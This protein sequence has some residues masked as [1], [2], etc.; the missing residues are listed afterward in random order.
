MTFQSVSSSK[1][2]AADNA[3]DKMSISDPSAV[4]GDR[5]LKTRHAAV[6]LTEHKHP[7]WGGIVSETL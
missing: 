7:D 4:T 2:Q 3:A 1:H 5:C 6:Q